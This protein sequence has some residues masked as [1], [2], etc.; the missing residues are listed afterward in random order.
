MLLSAG[1]F[2]LYLGESNIFNL[3]AP[4]FGDLAI[5]ENRA[6]MLEVWLGSSLF[7]ISGLEREQIEDKI[8]DGCRNAGDFLRT[9]M[10]EMARQQAAQRWADNAPE[11]IL[12]LRQI[13]QTIPDA[14]VIHMIRDGRDVSLS[15][16][17]KRYIKPFPWKERETPEGAALYWEW[18]VRKGRAAGAWL[19]EDYIEIRFEDVVS[20]PRSVLRAL[21]GFLEQELDYDVVLKNAV[22]AVAK[23]NTS[24]R[25][26]VKSDFNP[27]ARWKQ[28]FT[29]EQ[30]GRVEGL[31]GDTLGELGYEL[32]SDRQ[33]MPGPLNRAWSRLIYRQFFEM[34]LQWKKN[35][36]AH[37]IRHPLTAKEIDDVVLVD[38]AA[39][40]RMRSS[41]EPARGCTEGSRNLERMAQFGGKS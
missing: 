29:A 37:A 21:S 5:R 24:F 3:L 26:S 27:V 8:M 14:L 15:L 23:P 28:Q 22:G 1:G 7:R 2:V 41:A 12:H 32:A 35:R 9:V 17:E 39:A 20:D 6:K 33:E 25:G 18:M 10:D 16:S 30:L 38:V 36:L 34:K 4:R 40:D 31:I 11:E 19:G 13:K